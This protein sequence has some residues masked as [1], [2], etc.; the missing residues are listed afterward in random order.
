MSTTILN[1]DTTSE[2]TQIFVASENLSLH[3]VV[4]WLRQEGFQVESSWPDPESVQCTDEIMYTVLKIMQE[5][6]N[7]FCV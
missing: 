4:V 6:G 2:N 7:P 1:D 3:S 5:M